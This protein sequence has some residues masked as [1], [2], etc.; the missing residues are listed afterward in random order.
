MLL[1]EITDVIEAF[2][3]LNLQADYDNAGLLYGDPFQEIDSALL[4]ID[5]TEAVVDEAISNGNNMIISHH[6]L[7]LRGFKRITPQDD[8]SRA[9]VKAI[10]HN[11]AIYSAHT[12]IDSVQSG[13]SGKM[14]EKIGLESFDI[15]A[16]HK[17]M[18]EHGYGVIGNLPEPVEA[19]EFLSDLKEIFMLP[20]LRHTAIEVGEVRRIALCGGSG[21][22]LIKD[23]IANGA[24]IFITGDI[25]Y[26]DFFM[27]ENR[28]ILADIGHYESEQFTK[29]IFYELLTKKLPKFAVQFSTVKTNPINYL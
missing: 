27:A 17:P 10:Q 25:K 15:L 6:P 7:S 3:P 9:L 1:Q 19:F 12:N 2:A 26:H 22:S 13:V 28:I 21:S 14:A 20:V 4:T 24:D 23:A 29:E 5:V 16:P 18:A 11:I 8:S